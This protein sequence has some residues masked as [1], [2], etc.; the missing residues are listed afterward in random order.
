MIDLATQ[1]KYFEDEYRDF[2]S[3]DLVPAVQDYVK[4]KYN[5]T[6][7]GLTQL[8]TAI[9]LWLFGLINE[10]EFSQ[11]MKQECELESDEIDTIKFTIVSD[12]PEGLYRELQITY[13]L[14]TENILE[15]TNAD[16]EVGTGS[17][18]PM[19]T[20][21]DDMEKVH[22]YGA[23]AGTKTSESGV[24]PED[25]PVYKTE[26]E[27]VLQ[28]QRVADTPTYTS[29]ETS[30]PESTSEASAP[31]T[32]EPEPDTRWSSHYEQKE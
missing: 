26:Q 14:A 15:T 16:G 10:M 28:K 20:M 19:R 31:T 3:A 1:K 18:A 6:E 2:V 8:A 23:M 21:A 7:L 25:E 27:S 17:V 12:L 22:G 4:N 11:F 32:P 24:E 5:L 9:E 13:T 30:E 29:A